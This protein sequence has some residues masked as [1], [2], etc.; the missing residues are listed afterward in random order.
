MAHLRYSNMM[1][2]IVDARSILV[3]ASIALL[4]ALD[5]QALAAATS[6]STSQSAFL[7]DATAKLVANAVGVTKAWWSLPDMLMYRYADNFYNNGA[8]MAYPD[9]WLTSKEVGY[10]TGPPPP[11]QEPNMVMV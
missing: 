1:A 11:P 3:N 5:G 7:K 2:D 4:K 10:T 8:P 6:S 9:A